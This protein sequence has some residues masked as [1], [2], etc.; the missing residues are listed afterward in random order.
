MNAQ[1]Q[2]KTWKRIENERIFAFQA[3]VKKTNHLA[4][5]D[6][7]DHQKRNFM[8]SKTLVSLTYI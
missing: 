2:S 8:V 7:L 5:F 6:D 3:I 4:R 1:A